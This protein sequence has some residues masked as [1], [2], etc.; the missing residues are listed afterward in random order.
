M[1]FLSPEM[2]T[3][4]STKKNQ[5]LLKKN[6]LWH[7]WAKRIELLPSF[8]SNHCTVSQHPSL[9]VSVFVTVLF[10]YTASQFFSS[11][12]SPLS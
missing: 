5:F 12:H 10:V 7:K 9:F 11:F 2:N 8:S 4:L 1:E 6:L 3:K